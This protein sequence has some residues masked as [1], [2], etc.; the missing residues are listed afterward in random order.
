M[1]ILF[2]CS[3]DT[4][5]RLNSNPFVLSLKNGLERCGHQVDC[6]LDLFWN[7]Y[8]FYDILYFQWVEEIFNWNRT[9]I[10]LDKIKNHLY[11]IKKRG[12]KTVITCH[13]LHPHDND[14]LFTALY[15]LVYS[16]V[17]A[18]HHMGNWSFQFLSE[19]YPHKYHFIAPHHVA[20]SLFTSLFSGEEAKYK[21]HIPC[22][23]VVVSSFG[24][25]RNTNEINMFLKMAYDVGRRH[26]S[27]LAP[28]LPSL[29]RLYNGRMLN[30]TFDYIYKS[31]KYKYLKV[32]RAGFL[33]G[34]DLDL[35]LAASDIIFIQ[36][37]D[38][39]NSGNLP[40]AFA[41]GKV[42]VG[43]NI[44]NVGE[45]LRDTG[46]YVFSPTDRKSIC[47]AVL[48]AFRDIL[49]GKDLGKNNYEYALS[50]WSESVVC[51]SIS[52]NLSLIVNKS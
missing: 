23:D 48:N 19:K 40:L 47:M 13:N 8:Y 6:G 27:Y 14:A 17:D 36:R 44:G 11:T 46:N 43:P 32:K 49:L 38:I 26:I 3:T 37:L 15:D 31:I 50:N 41:K 34:E 39:L 21:L 35:W 52:F 45:I 7:D 42:V 18:F 33:S 30:L 28:R 51:S 25:F 2:V 22:K 5:F 9:I 24:A 29:G 1:K 10:D 16:E 20:N 12:I 4:V